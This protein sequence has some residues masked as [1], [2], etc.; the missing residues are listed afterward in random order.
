MAEVR[1]ATA[2]QADALALTLADA[3]ADDPLMRWLMPARNFPHRSQHVYR[4]MLGHALPHGTVDVVHD[5]TGAPVS[6]AI[7]LPPGHWKVPTFELVR[8]FGKVVRAAGY[9]LPRMLG[10]LTAVEKEH[11]ARPDHWYLE[12][13]GTVRARQ[14]R[15]IGSALL[16]HRTAQFDAQGVPAYLE[17]SNERN[18]PLYE[19]HGF[20]VTRKLDFPGQPPHWLMWR[21]PGRAEP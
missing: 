19:R 3:F 9:R 21:E 1:T 13:I 15:G 20:T 11:P 7:W 8:G 14:S 12:A 17:C 6:V 10:R 4:V 5:E 2:T 16:R 18:L